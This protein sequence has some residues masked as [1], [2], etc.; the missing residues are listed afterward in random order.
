[1]DHEPNVRL[2]DPHPEC[3]RR[4]DRANLLGHERFLNFAAV[5][6]VEARMIAGGW[7]SLLL[8]KK[9]QAID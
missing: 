5:S 2:V 8:E 1:M 3:I 9:A 4:D 6:I 7:N